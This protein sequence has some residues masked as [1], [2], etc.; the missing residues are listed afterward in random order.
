MPC[1]DIVYDCIAKWAQ[2]HHPKLEERCEVFSSR[3]GCLARFPY[4]SCRKLRRVLD[5][6]KDF[7]TDFVTKLVLEALFFKAEAPYRQRSI[8][9]ENANS[10]HHCFVER[11]YKLRPVKVVELE[12][13]HRQCTVY[14]NL[15]LE[16]C[17][18]LF[19]AGRMN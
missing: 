14:L 12:L 9:A 16:E 2:I 13:P 5:D 15:K 18:N 7:N 1:E 10:V 3:L 4:M 8:V 6:C 11:A 19:P 17:T